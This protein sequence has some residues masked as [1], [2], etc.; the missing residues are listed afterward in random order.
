MSEARFNVRRLALAGGD[1]VYND[2]HEKTEYNQMCS[3]NVNQSL[4][5]S[6]ITL[7]LIILSYIGMC[8][9]PTYGFI[10][11]GERITLM[12]LKIPFVEAFSTLE[13]IINVAIQIVA[14]ATGF[15]GNVLIEGIFA[16]LMD[17]ITASTTSIKWRCKT[18]KEDLRMKKLPPIQQKL[19]LLTILQ[20][21]RVVDG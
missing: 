17:S 18:F 14:F 3:E 2:S 5:K 21:I 8:F 13:F 9:L 4:R 7:M 1:L 6:F 11:H 20:Q 16:L 12:S 19:R 10:A 15:P